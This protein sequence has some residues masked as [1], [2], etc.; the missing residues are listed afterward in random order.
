MEQVVEKPVPRIL[1]GGQNSGSDNRGV[2]ERPNLATTDSAGRFDK[3]PFV[4]RSRGSSLGREYFIFPRASSEF[5]SSLIEARKERSSRWLRNVEAIFLIDTR[6]NPSILALP[7]SRT[8]NPA[9]RLLLFPLR[10]FG[11]HVGW[12][13]ISRYFLWFYTCQRASDQ[14]AETLYWVCG[15]A[16]EP[17]KNNRVPRKSWLALNCQELP[18]STHTPL[19]SRG[20]ILF[21]RRFDNRNCSGS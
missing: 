11:H 8:N 21:P 9:F 15:G 4:Y 20:W 7:R 5:R 16:S 2:L 10:E 13:W 3:V 19:C 14:F 1:V 6:H 17:R 18:L 12:T